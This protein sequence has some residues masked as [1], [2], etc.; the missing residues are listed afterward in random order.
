MPMDFPD[1]QSLKQCAQSHKF[2]QPHK[3]ELEKDYREALANHVAKIDNV[4]SYE[5]RY[6]VGWDQWTEEQKRNIFQRE[7][8]L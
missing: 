1:M 4:E 7:G 5:I 2:R 3:N 6:S 8:L